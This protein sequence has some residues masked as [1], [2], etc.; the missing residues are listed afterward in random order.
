MIAVP[1]R[2]PRGTRH[3]GLANRG[4]TYGDTLRPRAD[5][6]PAVERAEL[7]RDELAEVTS[8]PGGTLLVVHTELDCDVASPSAHG[9]VEASV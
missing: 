2:H 3:E 5:D 1:E 7:V 6:H 4:D 9:V 8:D